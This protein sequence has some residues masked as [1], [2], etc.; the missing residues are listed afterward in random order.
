MQ[1]SKLQIKNQNW[2]RDKLENVLDLIIDHRGKTPKKLGGSWTSNGIPAL[3][4]KNI[5]G[6]KIINEKDIRYVSKELYNKWMPIKLEAGDILLTS[7]A[8]LGE[9]L[10]LK[11][12]VDYCLSQRLFTLRVNEKKLESRFLYYYLQSP[13]GLHE[14]TRRM[15]G[16]AAEGIRQAE[17]RQIEIA[18]PEDINEQKRIAKILSVFDEKIELN[19]KISQILEEMASAIFKEWFIKFRF[20]GYE[21]VKFVDSELGKIPK[22]WEVR[23]LSDL[24]SFRGGSQ[25][26]KTEH[27]YEKREG[28]IR[29]VQNRDYSIDTHKT[30]IPISNKNKLCNEY[31]ILIDKYGEVGTVRFGITGAYNVALAKIEPK[32]SFLREFLRL[33]FQQKSIKNMIESSAVASTRG[34]LNQ[35]TFTGMKIVEPTNDLLQNFEKIVRTILEKILQNKKEN[36]TLASLRDLLLPK[37]MSGEVRLKV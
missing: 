27:I 11:E 22:E 25:P 23:K 5:K 8:P 17:L 34:S 33:Y 13:T 14:L 9:L 12:K 3:S 1:K 20:P 30:Y 21:K 26:P 36:Q 7:E 32:K 19:N 6:G 2:R 10:Y 28:Y 29:F 15:S 18:F 31:D 4:A 24:F 35:N 37:L 16:T